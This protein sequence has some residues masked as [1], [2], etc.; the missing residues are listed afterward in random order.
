MSNIKVTLNP[1]YQNVSTF[2]SDLHAHFEHEGVAIYD[3]RN[4]VKLFDVDGVS[5]VVKRYKRPYF[6]QR[7]D[8]T[9]FRPSKAIRAYKYA[10]KMR[11]MGIDTPDAVACV[12][13]YSFGIF[14]VGYFVST[15]CGDPDMKI[16]KENPDEKLVEAF[17]GFIVRMHEN[18][19]M[20]GDL[21]L[22]NI[23][24]RADSDAEKGFH[25][26]VIDTNR[27]RFLESPSKQQCLHNL[28]R[29]SHDRDLNRK[30]IGYYA[31]MRGWNEDGCV[32]TVERMLDTFE[33]RRRIKRKIK[34]KK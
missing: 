30:I 1:A 34:K 32:Q 28:V 16:I 8:Y 25:F 12:E 33:R 29:V 23:L 11:R 13:V 21:N 3:K 2:V 7:L 4:K 20:H 26:T 17:A 5:Y 31:R 6:I 27:S 18:G 19:V 15:Y 14:T 22:S 24:Y 10:L 9:F